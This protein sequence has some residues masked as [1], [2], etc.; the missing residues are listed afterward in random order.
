MRMKCTRL[1]VQ[2]L[3]LSFLG[4]PV[5]RC[6]AELFPLSM[7]SGTSPRAQGEHTREKRPAGSERWI[8]RRRVGGRH[9]DTPNVNTLATL[10]ASQERIQSEIE[11]RSP[12]AMALRRP[13]TTLTVSA[14]CFDSA[15]PAQH[16]TP[17]RSR[18]SRLASGSLPLVDVVGVVAT[19]LFA[20]CRF[21]TSR[22]GTPRDA[23]TTISL[24]K[25]GGKRRASDNA[26][27]PPAACADPELLQGDRT[28]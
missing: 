18:F 3:F 20:H 9:F 21:T 13:P 2:P 11:P 22:P 15:N 8:I 6:S 26:R 24:S 23:P 19:T 28:G 17:I 10:L 14:T 4:K 25:D 16:A 27:T 12:A 7:N 1:R 5:A